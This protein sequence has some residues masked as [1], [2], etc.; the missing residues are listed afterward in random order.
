MIITVGNLIPLLE[1]SDP[2][3]EVAAKIFFESDVALGLHQNCRHDC[4]R[5]VTHQALE[6]VDT[7]IND[8]E[9]TPKPMMDSFIELLDD[10][11][12]DAE[13][14]AR[15]QEENL[16]MEERASATYHALEELAARESGAA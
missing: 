2:N 6:Y 11:A 1:E 15:C 5:K 13:M 9:F 3:E 16:A 4:S 12:E 8:D 14:Q 10:A 7:I